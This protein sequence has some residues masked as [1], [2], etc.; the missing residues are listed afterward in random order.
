MHQIFTK[1]SAYLLTSSPEGGIAMSRKVG[2]R[3]HKIPDFS[4]AKSTPTRPPAQVDLCVVAQGHLIALNASRFFP[5]AE[6]EENRPA[7]LCSRFSNRAGVTSLRFHSLAHEEASSHPACAEKYRF[8]K[9]K[10]LAVFSRPASRSARRF[11]T[12]SKRGPRATPQRRD[13]SCEN[14]QVSTAHGHVLSATR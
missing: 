9:T 14:K 11:F 12:H 3:P 8:W 4:G 13:L 1:E 2:Q 6:G 5:P 7:Q 10:V